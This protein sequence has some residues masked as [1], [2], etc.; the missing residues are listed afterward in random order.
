MKRFK[1]KKNELSYYD[2]QMR[3]PLH[4]CLGLYIGYVVWSLLVPLY[5]GWVLGYTSGFNYLAVVISGVGVYA[6]HGHF[7]QTVPLPVLLILRSVQFVVRFLLETDY[8]LNLISFASLVIIEVI[9]SILEMVD[10]V[11]FVYVKE[12][13]DV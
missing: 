12:K 7:N 4:V 8:K 6:M 5:D 13:G 2:R 1:K 10:R 3:S 9:L 11:T